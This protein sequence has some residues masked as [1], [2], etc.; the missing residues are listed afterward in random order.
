VPDVTPVGRS[1]TTSS[2]GNDGKSVG[3][4]VVVT[5]SVGRGTGTL[6]VVT[7]DVLVVL[8]GNDVTGN[9]AEVV[10][11]TVINVGTNLS[12]ISFWTAE[13]RRINE[14]KGEEK[15]SKDVKHFLFC[16]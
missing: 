8:T 6:H 3:A 11:G 5:A 9:G 12:L 16:K 7:V 1:L 13:I 4:N 15:T 10:D 14:K 2:S